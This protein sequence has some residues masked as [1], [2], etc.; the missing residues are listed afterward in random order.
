MSPD[1]VEISR[2]EFLTRFVPGAAVAVVVACGGLGFLLR[3]RSVATQAEAPFEESI[4]ARGEE[5]LVGPTFA[6]NLLL[7]ERRDF[8]DNEG[9][10]MEPVRLKEVVR[11]IA[12]RYIEVTGSTNVTVDSLVG[13][14]KIRFFTSRKAYEDAV[15]ELRPEYRDNFSKRSSGFADQI[16][17]TILIDLSTFLSTNGISN[18]GVALIKALWHDFGHLDLSGRNEGELLGIFMVGDIPPG[19]R[20]KY[21]GLEVLYEDGSARPGFG[22]DRYA[23]EVFLAVV[24]QLMIEDERLHEVGVPEDEIKIVLQG[25]G[26]R[27][28]IRYQ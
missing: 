4:V 23:E 11:A 1:Q 17:G 22:G 8:Y 12:E 9:N 25:D 21:F 6:E 26:Y 2:R 15:F 28:G 10:V 27:E 13:V 19:G 24:T 18:L 3:E 7:L 14:D 20:Q 16:S 5:P